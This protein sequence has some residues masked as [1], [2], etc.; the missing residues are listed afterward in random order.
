[1]SRLGTKMLISYYPF[2]LLRQRLA[3]QGNARTTYHYFAAQF[4]YRAAFLL[5]CAPIIALPRPLAVAWGWGAVLV[6]R[7]WNGELRRGW[8]FALHR[9]S[10]ML[11]L[12]AD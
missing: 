5:F 7:V 1:V 3:K 11:T 12:R 8:H 10:L 4:R 9:L 6:G 2:N